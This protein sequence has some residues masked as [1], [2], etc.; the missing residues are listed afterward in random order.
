VSEVSELGR[1]GRDFPTPHQRKDKGEADTVEIAE[2]ARTVEFCHRPSQP[3]SS[4]AGEFRS[5]F[6]VPKLPMKL[7]S[8]ANRF[9]NFNGWQFALAFAGIGF[10]P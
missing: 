10:K 7:L 4:H 1:L 9:S 6:P 2:P 8:V 3:G 5:E